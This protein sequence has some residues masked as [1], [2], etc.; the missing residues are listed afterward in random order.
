MTFESQLHKIREYR[1]Y[2]PSVVYNRISRSRD[3][4]FYLEKVIGMHNIIRVLQ[5]EKGLS[6]SAFPRRLEIMLENC[7]GDYC[8]AGVQKTIEEQKAHIN[9]FFLKK[10]VHLLSATVPQSST[11]TVPTGIYF[12]NRPIRSQLAV[13]KAADPSSGNV[14]PLHIQNVVILC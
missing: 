8:L 6:K 1:E 3:F 11:S 2:F 10:F 4:Q 9:N 7:T 14:R 12:A 13:A 5:S